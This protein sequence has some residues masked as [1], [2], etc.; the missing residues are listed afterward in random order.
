VRRAEFMLQAEA[1]DVELPQR[2]ETL[3]ADQRQSLLAKQGFQVGQRREDPLAGPIATAIHDR[4]EQLQTVVAHADRVRLGK[5]QADSAMG[6]DS[7][8]ANLPLWS[9]SGNC[10]L[11]WQVAGPLLLPA[12]TIF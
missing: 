11:P 9:V 7:S 8:G 3:Q 1:D 4:V 6:F 5:R 2:R 12:G 10:K